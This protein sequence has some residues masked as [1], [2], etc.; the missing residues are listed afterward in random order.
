VG[1]VTFR[2]QV[3]AEQYGS[4]TIE[5][6]LDLP[7]GIGQAEYAALALST[8]REMVHAELAKSPSKNVRSALMYPPSEREQRWRQAEE[9][10]EL[11]L[12]AGQRDIA[13]LDDEADS[14]DLPY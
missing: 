13:R 8:A 2:K 3:P 7:E 5:V 14:E 10:A 4:E 12:A 1:T 6:T 9:S 11:E